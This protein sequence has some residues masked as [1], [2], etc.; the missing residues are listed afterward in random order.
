MLIY[1]GGG[2]RT[3]GREPI[4]LCNRN[5]W[6]FQAIFAGVAAPTFPDQPTPRRLIGNRLWVFAPDCV[7]GWVGDGAR[8]CEVGVFHFPYVAETLHN[9]MPESGWLS[10]DLTPQNTKEVHRYISLGTEQLRAPSPLSQLYFQS[11]LTGLSILVMQEL[12][13]NQMSPVTS[14]ARHAVGAAISWYGAH[15]HLAPTLEDAAQ[16][17]SVSP[18]HLRRMFHQTTAMSPK[19]AFDQLRFQRA[20]E[21]L[22]EPRH[23]IESIA[24]LTGF[25]SA[26][27]FSRAF[28]HRYGLSP[29]QWRNH[30]R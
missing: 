29:K 26:S 16:H 19:Q 2:T 20:H 28:K 13:V 22:E 27:A 21:L 12:E 1:L 8:E 3:Y 23:T 24:E 9:I 14:H 10:V 15:L 30:L 4:P 6:E 5:L 18:A 7:H 11:I 25:C 17:V